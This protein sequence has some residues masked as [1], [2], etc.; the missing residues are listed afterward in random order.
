MHSGGVATGGPSERRHHH[1]PILF[2]RV[3]SGSQRWPP[4]PSSPDP[5]LSC[6]GSQRR[7][8]SIHVLDGVSSSSS[9]DRRHMRTEEVRSYTPPPLPKTSTSS[10]SSVLFVCPTGSVSSMMPTKN[11]SSQASHLS[12]LKKKTSHLSAEDQNQTCSPHQDHQQAL[13]FW[14]KWNV[15]HRWGTM[16]RIRKDHWNWKGCRRCHQEYQNNVGKLD[17]SPFLYVCQPHIGNTLTLTQPQSNFHNFIN[18][19]GTLE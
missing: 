5:I 17:Q 2:Y 7:W 3:H 10:N 6:S 8:P 9:L 16:S 12:R 19:L 4:S 11:S 13:S 1:P 15:I 18:Y 14:L